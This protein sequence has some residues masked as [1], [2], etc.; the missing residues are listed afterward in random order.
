[1]KSPTDSSEGVDDERNGEGKEMKVLEVEIESAGYEAARPIIKDLTFSVGA[2]KLVGL[3]GPNGAGK[4]TTVKAI[5]GLLKECRGEIRFTGET[6]RYAY[7]PE[8]PVTL[9]GLT[10]EEHLELAA[11]VFQL[12][13]L[14]RR[15]RTEELLNSFSLQGVRHQ[16]P[17]SFSKG[18]RQKMMLIL[19]FLIEPEVLIVDEPF[20]GLDPRA[21]QTFLRWM[22]RQR[23]RG[24]GVLMSTHVLDT[25]ERICDTFLLID[26]GRLTAAGNMEE[27]RERSGLAEGTLLDC[28]GRLSG[29]ESGR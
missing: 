13:Q 15:E 19:A 9:E 10:L 26:G 7:V 22:E 21:I 17:E 6:K 12:P 3:I 27:I 14:A 16:Y 4:S 8:Q 28:F 20:I 1:M 18:M 2:G 11:A 5:L 23:K 24:T 25:A 29:E